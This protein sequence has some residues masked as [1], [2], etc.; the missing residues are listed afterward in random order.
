[1]LLRRIII[2][3]WGA[4]HLF[5]FKSRNVHQIKM[6]SDLPKERALRGEMCWWTTIHLDHLSRISLNRSYYLLF[7]QLLQVQQDLI[8]Q[9]E[10]KHAQRRE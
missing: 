1:M 9:Q 5:P 2:F 7:N 3:H 8:L 4:C 10:V 6:K